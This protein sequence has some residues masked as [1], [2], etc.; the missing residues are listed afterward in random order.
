MPHQI[1][2]FM[3]NRPGKLERVTDLLADQ[4]I[5][6]RAI[7]ITDSGDF[8]ILKLLVNDPG[9]ACDILTGNGLVAV[10]KEV[11]AIRVIDSPGGLR[12]IGATLT[13]HRINIDD[14]YGFVLRSGQ[15][16]VFVIQVHNP[17]EVAVILKE[18]GFSLLE[19]KDL[20][21]L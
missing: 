17:E 13:R 4:G 18:E 10:L 5:N 9:K 1:S 2:V 12:D 14:A 6:I 19:E 16:A 20:Y 21:Q 3:E 15:S 8:G 7:T 11:V